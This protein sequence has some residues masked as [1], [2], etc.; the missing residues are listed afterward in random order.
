[1]SGIRIEPYSPPWI[2]QNV[3]KSAYRLP[4]VAQTYLRRARR[5][6]PEAPP[7][8]FVLTERLSYGARWFITYMTHVM[9]SRIQD[10]QFQVWRILL[11]FQGVVKARLQPL[12]HALVLDGSLISIMD[13]VEQGGPF[14]PDDWLHMFALFADELTSE[15]CVEAD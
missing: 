13:T 4:S 3:K 9:K 12:A 5:L 7:P 15:E 2:A 10:H 8:E 1:M 11:L 6:R 14:I